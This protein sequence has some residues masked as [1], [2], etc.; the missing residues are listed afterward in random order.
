MPAPL[1]PH[2]PFT[3]PPS[4]TPALAPPDRLFAASLSRRYP[5]RTPARDDDAAVAGVLADSDSEPSLVA[6]Q[7]PPRQRQLRRTRHGGPGEGGGGKTE[8]ATATEG[9]EGEFVNRR[10]EDGGY[11]LGVTG[12]GATMEVPAMAVG[13]S[14]ADAEQQATD[15]H[16]AAVARRFFAAGGGA[17]ATRLGRKQEEGEWLGVTGWAMG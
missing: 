11:L 1:L 7:Q 17:A 2:D 5:M 4:H 6:R 13:R 16:Y 3:E 8:A 9:D 15:R 12:Y 14:A 10:A